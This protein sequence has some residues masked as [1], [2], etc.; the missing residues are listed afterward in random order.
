MQLACKSGDRGVH[1]GGNDQSKLIEVG[2]ST[3]R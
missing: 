1:E 3:R 2:G